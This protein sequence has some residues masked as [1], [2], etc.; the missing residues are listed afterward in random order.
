MIKFFY[1]I[2]KTWLGGILLHWIFARFSFVIP[3]DKL[4]ETESILAFHHP[5]PAYSLH[6]LIVP[7][8]KIKSLKE[9]PSEKGSF[10]FDLFE[11]VKE[12]VKRFDLD[13]KGYRLIAN[14]GENQEVGHLHFHLVSE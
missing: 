9:L 14:G 8:E 5:S 1:L 4:I 13:Q 12:L 11:A 2:A 10:E 6:I 7:K 3:G